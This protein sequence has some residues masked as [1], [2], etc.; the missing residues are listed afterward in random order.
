MWGWIQVE[1]AVEAQVL[2]PL[3][4]K[5]VL[6]L[7]PAGW[8]HR[9]SGFRISSEVSLGS[10]LSGVV[11]GMISCQVSSGFSTL[12]LW[13]GWIRWY[14]WCWPGLEFNSSH[15]FLGKRFLI[16]SGWCGLSVIWKR[17][18]SVVLRKITP[19]VGNA[20]INTEAPL[21]FHIQYDDIE[22]TR[23]KGYV[24]W[25]AGFREFCCCIRA[26]VHGSQG[27]GPKT[28]FFEGSGNNTTPSDCLN[29]AIW[30]VNMMVGLVRCH[31]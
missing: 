3:R 17:P 2:H 8:V 22:R 28:M 20:C 5:G 18:G 29:K 30:R 21:A 14:V 9:W 1:V 6:L 24:P 4:L 10:G 23:S 16:A 15:R 27:G 12:N 26:T 31:N 19:E 7:L 11:G 25:G 13:S